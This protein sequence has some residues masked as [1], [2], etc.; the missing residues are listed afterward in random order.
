MFES[1]ELSSLTWDSAAWIY[2]VIIGVVLVRYFMFIANLLQEPKALKLYYPYLSFILANILHLYASWY[3]AKKTYT[4]IEGDTLQ[5]AARSFYDAT[6]CIAGLIIVPKDK[7]L[8]DF[9]DMKSWFMKA[10]KSYF[11]MMVLCYL[12]LQIQAVLGLFNI[13]EDSVLTTGQLIYV[14]GGTVPMILLNV[15]SAFSKN[16]YYLSFHGTL[17]LV[18]SLIGLS[19]L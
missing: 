7:L 3:M 9:F 19:M 4:G 17:M 10:K 16:D 6:L 12:A 1:G 15:V 13:T 11:F 5:F 8:E 18:S 2:S 14:A